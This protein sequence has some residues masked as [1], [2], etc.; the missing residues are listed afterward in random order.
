MLVLKY[1]NTVAQN[2]YYI[3]N[4]DGSYN[5]QGEYLGLSDTAFAGSNTTGSLVV[6]FGEV[7]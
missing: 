6:V 3:A 7:A 1:D 5:A 2:S 4:A